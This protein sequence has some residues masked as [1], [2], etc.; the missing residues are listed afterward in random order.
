MRIHS[1]IFTC[2][3]LNPSVITFVFDADVIRFSS[4]FTVSTVV[5]PI[6]SV[7]NEPR[8]L[9]TTTA[10]AGDKSN[11]NSSEGVS[12]SGNVTSG[13]LSGPSTR[14]SKD[15][16]ILCERERKSFNKIFCQVRDHTKV[17][18]YLCCSCDIAE[19]FDIVFNSSVI[20]DDV[21]LAVVDC[22]RPI[23]AK[24]LISDMEFL[25]SLKSRFSAWAF[26]SDVERT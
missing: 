8:S 9:G 23:V 7:V 18:V 6:C 22:D 2:S 3:L 5:P 13:S 12:P 4:N 16:R 1:L 25:M 24:L 11:C 15:D 14:F 21:L 10:I 19:L 20:I 26:I 17:M